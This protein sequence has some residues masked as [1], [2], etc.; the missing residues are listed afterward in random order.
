MS[1]STNVYTISIKQTG[2]GEK[3]YW[4]SCGVA[5]LNRDDEDGRD[6]GPPRSI[7]IK[8]DLFPN[9]EL[10]AFPRRERSDIP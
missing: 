1:N 8:L 3:T 4:K 7:A 6:A 5:F 10:V 9:V 2:T